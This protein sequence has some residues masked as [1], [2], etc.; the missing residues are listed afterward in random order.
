MNNKSKLEEDAIER[1]RL[2]GGGG[3]QPG[4]YATATWIGCCSGAD[5]RSGRGEEPNMGLL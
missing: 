1:G 2:G 5:L 4:G 3:A